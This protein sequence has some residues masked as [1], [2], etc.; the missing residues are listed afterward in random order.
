ML[1][2]LGDLKPWHYYLFSQSLISKLLNS[3]VVSMNGHITLFLHLPLT[4]TDSEFHSGYKKT[5]T[6]K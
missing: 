1:L 4:F 5:P 6:F 3:L 2:F